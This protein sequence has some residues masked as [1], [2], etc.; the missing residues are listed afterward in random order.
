MN[1][2]IKELPEYEVAYCRRYGSYFEPNEEHWEKFLNW[3][4]NKG[5]FPPQQSFI[6]ISLDN[7]DLVESHNCRHDAC[8]TIPEGFDKEVHE[9]MQF[10]KL[11]GGQYALYQYYDS[12]SMLNS[13]YKYMYEQW[14]PNS[15]FEPDY[16]RYN[17]EFSMN[18]PV[19][20]PDGKA[21]VHLFV[22]V[23]KRTSY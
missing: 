13:G 19:E 7:P 8:V 3:A 12:P 15:D 18:N 23:K 10:R 16:D 21:K 4:I 14:F 11:D 17:L 6:G 5:L 2:L 20:D 9:N 22:P 1:I